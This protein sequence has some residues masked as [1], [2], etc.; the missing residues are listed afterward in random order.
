MSL[1]LGFRR[2]YEPHARASKL[3]LTPLATRCTRASASA[4]CS[5]GMGCSSS[6]LCRSHTLVGM[7]RSSRDLFV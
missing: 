6:L 3:E 1:L 5:R 4:M 2:L 7:L